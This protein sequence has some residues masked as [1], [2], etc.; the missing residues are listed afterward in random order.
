MIGIFPKLYDDELVYSWLARYLVYS[1]YTSAM[2]AYRDLYDNIKIHPSVELMNNMTKNAREV[3]E[4]T[5]PLKELVHKHTLFPEYARFIAPAK[6]ERLLAELDFTRGNWI[7]TI[8]RP[9]SFGERHLKYCPICVREDRER[10]GETYWHR[11]HQIF[12][13]GICV[14]HGVYL[15]N[16]CVV[17]ESKLTRLK[18]AEIVIGE[19]K[20]AVICEDRTIKKLAEYMN[21]VFLSPEYSN[22]QI[23]R[24]LAERIDARYIRSNGERHMYELYEAYM[25]FYQSLGKQGLMSQN[26]MSR[27]FGGRAGLFGHICQLGLFEGIKPEELLRAEVESG[28]DNIYKRVAIR[29]GEPIDKV[30]L[31]GEALMEEWK[32]SRAPFLRKE[33]QKDHLDEEDRLLAPKVRA[34]AEMIYG[35]GEA[36]PRKVSLSLVSRE[37]HV[38]MH[39]LKRMKKCMEELERYQ[40]SQERYWARELVWAVRELERRGEPMNFKRIRN[41]INLRRENILDSLD[42]L[43]AIDVEIYAIVKSFLL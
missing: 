12:G 35:I 25:T 31:I 42:E 7:N 10:Y 43:R 21:E 3:M 40:E 19:E 23:G 5:A 36:R 30:K 9:A 27:L 17:V 33:R 22:D 1:G 34:A 11:Q 4:R 37:L 28:E 20:A 32:K 14:K 39:K 24:Y 8:M 2:D 41:L 26:V 18:A 13:I 15:F 29:T 16:S 38:D 6:R